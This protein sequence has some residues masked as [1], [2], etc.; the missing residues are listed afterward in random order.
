ML[1]RTPLYEPHA[2]LGARLVDFAGMGNA[3]SDEYEVEP[4]ELK[5]KQ[6]TRL[7]GVLR[8]SQLTTVAN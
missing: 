3:G 5:T 4:A 8:N 7:T 6:E 2:S 1:K